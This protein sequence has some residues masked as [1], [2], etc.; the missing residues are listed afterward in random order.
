LE[1]KH[2]DELTDIPSQL[3]IHFMQFMQRS[4]MYI[5]PCT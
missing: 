5:K 2:E 1:M 3:C 4:C